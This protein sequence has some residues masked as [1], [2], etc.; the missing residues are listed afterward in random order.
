M[1]AYAPGRRR[2]ARSVVRK[3]SLIVLAGVACVSG[4][5]VSA[6][7]AYDAIPERE[8]IVIVPTVVV[9]PTAVPFR[10]VGPDLG[11]PSAYAQPLE[12]PQGPRTASTVLLRVG[13]AEGYVVVGTLQAG[14]P[15]NAVGRDETGEWVA[16][17]FPPNATLRAWLL[18]GQVLDVGDMEAL[19]VVPLTYLP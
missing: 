1:I 12:I 8:V 2:T 3:W 6:K 11:L 5:A 7:V 15:V 19:P 18:A 17:E 16:I 9:P 13:P 4:V 14:S 10:P